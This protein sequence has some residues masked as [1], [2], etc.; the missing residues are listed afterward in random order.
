MKVKEFKILV[1]SWDDEDEVIM[2]K[3]GEGNNFSPFSTYSKQIYVPDCT[4][5]GEVY[6]RGLTPKMIEQGYSEEDLYDGNNGVNAIVL[7]PTN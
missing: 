7:W 1:N 3:D 6:Q 5:S 4:W 2:S